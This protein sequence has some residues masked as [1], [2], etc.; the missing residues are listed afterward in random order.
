MPRGQKKEVVYT[1]KALKLHEKVQKLEADLKAAK[2][3]LKVAYK[4]QLKAEKETA[5]REKRAAAAAA[6]KALK[7]N[8]VK[9]LK[10]IEESGKTPEEILALIENK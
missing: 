5:A 3:D 2:E 4:E 8:K 10:A 6:K 1:G 9:I 7:E